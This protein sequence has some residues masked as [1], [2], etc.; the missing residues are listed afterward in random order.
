MR[1]VP[2]SFTQPEKNTRPTQWSF[3]SLEEQE[4]IDDADWW[5]TIFLFPFHYSCGWYRL[6]TSKFLNNVTDSPDDLR[7]S[8]F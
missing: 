1:S 6:T 7:S 2:I 8:G 4:E 5:K 3:N